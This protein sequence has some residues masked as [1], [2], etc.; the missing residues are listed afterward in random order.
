MNRQRAIAFLLM[1]AVSGVVA[2]M[3]G[4]ATFPAVIWAVALVGLSGRLS[5]DV[6]RSTR[7]VAVLV[8]T[9]AF[10]GVA[11]IVPEDPKEA[12]PLSV[13][14]LTYIVAWYFMVLMAGAFFVRRRGPMPRTFPLY[15]I[16]ALICSGNVLVGHQQDRVY[17]LAAMAVT[18]M[19]AFYFAA[20]RKYLPAAQ[21]RELL[22]RKAAGFLVLLVALVV[23]GSASAFVYA[24]QQRINQAISSLAARLYSSRVM[25]FSDEALL[26]S[27]MYLKTRG[28]EKT[29]L[30]VFSRRPPGYLRG[31]AFVRPLGRRW[32]AA[33]GKTM[34]R[35]S[36]RRFQGIPDPP[37][38]RKL[39]AL[40]GGG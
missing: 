9:M 2:Y 38:G 26:R 18:V 12:S 34:L 5:L 15:A 35:P 3:S 36:E 10:V 24:N 11:R 25:G 20:E 33:K 7:L 32:Y 27:M 30:R 40:G 28:A 8:V 4:R 1:T 21:G 31:R 13:L 6:S 29:A 39:F 16:I 22:G 14:A 17:M 23:A 37:A 19:T